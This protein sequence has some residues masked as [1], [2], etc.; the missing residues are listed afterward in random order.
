MAACILDSYIAMLSEDV[1][2]LTDDE[3]DALEDRFD[4]EIDNCEY[5]TFAGNP[6]PYSDIN[7][8]YGLDLDALHTEIEDWFRDIALRQS[9]ENLTCIA[10]GIVGAVPH[11]YAAAGVAGEGYLSWDTELHRMEHPSD[12]GRAAL[13]AAI[14][15]CLNLREIPAAQY[16]VSKIAAAL[17]VHFGRPV[18]DEC[19]DN[20]YE[21]AHMK[22]AY[23][24]YDIFYDPIDEFVVTGIIY[25][26]PCHYPVLDIRS[27]LPQMEE[28]A[29]AETAACAADAVTAILDEN[30]ASTYTEDDF[31]SAYD[32]YLSESEMEQLERRVEQAYAVCRP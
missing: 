28:G 6:A 24:A 17:E 12:N 16:E 1:Y 4:T 10:D 19:W 22:S 27:V 15:G 29:S 20:M 23:I 5:A 32:S 9:D 7:A 3:S 30:R 2:Y 21:S 18:T 25:D 13:T 11:M 14:S 31:V 26:A 8:P